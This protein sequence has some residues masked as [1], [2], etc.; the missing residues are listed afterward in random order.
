[1]IMPFHL[2]RSAVISRIGKYLRVGRCLHTIALISF[3]V[4][5]SCFQYAYHAYANNQVS[6]CILLLLLSGIACAIPVFAELDAYSRY[7]NYKMIRDLLFCY[8]FRKMIIGKFRHSRCQR[9]AVFFASCETGFRKHVKQYFDECGYRWYHVLPDFL[10]S[11]PGILC[12]QSFWLATFFTKT[13]TPK[14]TFNKSVRVS[15]A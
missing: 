7:Q 8:G 11:K 2:F 13:Y 12:T 3:L 10:F 15:Y 5:F 6:Y 9:E 4:P 14:F 1:M